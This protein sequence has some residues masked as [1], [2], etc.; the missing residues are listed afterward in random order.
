[1]GNYVITGVGNYVIVNPSNLGN[2]LI[3]DTHSPSLP[4]WVT[5]SPMSLPPNTLQPAAVTSI[6]W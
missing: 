3:A 6:I 5:T 4:A 2:Y 1:M